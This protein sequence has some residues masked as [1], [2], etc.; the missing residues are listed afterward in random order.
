M[1]M[2]LAM[3]GILGNLQE[4]N[5]TQSGM[6]E[7]KRLTSQA[8]YLCCPECASEV[9][10]HSTNREATCLK[11]VRPGCKIHASSGLDRLI[12]AQDS[13]TNMSGEEIP[14]QPSLRALSEV[15]HGMNQ[16]FCS[17]GLRATSLG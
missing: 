7:G 9:L 6:L 11:L 14:S 10:G 12:L 17:H 2:V 15:L 8:A 16:V 3:M 5:N 4:E 13:A 1:E